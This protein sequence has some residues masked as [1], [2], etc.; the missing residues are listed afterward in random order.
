MFDSVLDRGVVPRRRLAT[1]AVISVLGHAAVLSLALLVR[2]PKSVE[3]VT[4]V[5]VWPTV[6][7][8]FTPAPAPGPAAAAA[9]PARRPSRPAR[10][11]ELLV[12][13]KIPLLPEVEP[14][15]DVKPDP[16]T[17][18]GARVGDPI[19]PKGPG[20]DGPGG[21]GGGGGGG[22]PPGGNGSCAGDA[23]PS[24]ASGMTR[25]V[26]LDRGREPAYTREALEAH[27]EGPMIV[28]CVVTLSG[29]LEH[30]SVIQSL[31]YMERA[32]VEALMTRR[33]SPATLGGKQLAVRYF[34]RV[35]L[36]LPH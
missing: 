3:E 6:P 24:F 13:A 10:S 33:Y 23:C 22:G 30:C 14:P 29:R 19:G 4:K 27:I 15:P 20:T 36:E 12:P 21:G 34:F 1:G 17:V 16:D 25:P 9:A 35:K 7:P 5:I 32:V 8:M 2:P 18:V 31:P 26:L 28:Q 11:R